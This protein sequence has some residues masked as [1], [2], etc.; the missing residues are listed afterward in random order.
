M[1]ELEY[2]SQYEGTEIDAAVNFGKNPDALP[3]ENSTNGVTSGGVF[4]AVKT[5]KETLERQ[6]VNRNL[7]D[8][9]YFK[10]DQ[11]EGYVV[12]PNKNYYSDTA[13]TTLV[14]QTNEHTTVTAKASGYN[15]I[16][17]G[18]TDY[19]VA[20]ADCVR[21]YTASGFSFDMW[22]INGNDRL[23]ILPTDYGIELK[24]TISSYSEYFQLL[25]NDYSKIPKELKGVPLIGSMAFHDGTI[26]TFD[27]EIPL[28]EPSIWTN[29]GGSAHFKLNYDNGKV[30]VMIVSSSDLQIEGVK[31][32]KGSVSTLKAEID[33]G[34]Y[35]ED[36]DLMACY[37]HGLYRVAPH[38][39]YSRFGTAIGASA[40]TLMI[41]IPQPFA[42]DKIPTLSLSGNIVVDNHKG[43][44]SSLLSISEGWL[45]SKG[46]ICGV[47]T[48]TN[49]NIVVGDA[50]EVYA[51]DDRNA[52]IDVNR[53]L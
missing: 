24:N 8:N 27:V 25:W 23:V 34:D 7:L 26:E 22:V 46:M 10:I 33:S 38:S 18:G 53:E 16:N 14:G 47:A 6:I 12:P 19:Y 3:T 17:I 43:S 42:S 21:G 35:D 30:R 52:Y 20:V 50:Y 45:T 36:A 5:A 28:E 29:F 40:N 11:R 49:S 2:I 31:L 13:L 41:F 39:N 1:A 32:E 15:T 9:P 37:K 48:A 51:S 4:T 44:A